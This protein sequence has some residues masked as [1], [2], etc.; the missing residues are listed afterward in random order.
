MPSNN[1]NQA[2]QVNQHR[3]EVDGEV[4]AGKQSD[5]MQKVL[6]LVSSPFDA[7]A[8]CFSFAFLIYSVFL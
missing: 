7:E 5:A 1:Q 2:A 4:F 8:A 3:Q 6:A